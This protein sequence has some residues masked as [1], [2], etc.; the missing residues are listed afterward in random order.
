MIKFT[1]LNNS[2]CRELLK[3]AK[4]SFYFFF[5][6]QNWRTGGQNR[7]CGRWGG[8]LGTSGRGEVAEKE[9]RRVNMVQ[10]L[11]THK[12]KC[13]NDTCSHY[14]RNGEGGQGKRELWRG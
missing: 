2:L 14:S 13:E 11:C 5:L 9:G 3:Q 7:F 10:I 12:Y 1:H 8:E 4:M 6:L